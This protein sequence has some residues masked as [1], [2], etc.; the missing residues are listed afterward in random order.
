MASINLAFINLIYILENYLCRKSH[1]IVTLDTTEDPPSCSEGA[2]ESRADQSPAVTYE[3]TKY[4]IKS[5]SFHETSKTF[6]NFKFDLLTL[7]RTT[8]KYYEGLISRRG[9]SP[10]ESSSIAGRKWRKFNDEFEI[11]KNKF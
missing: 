6:L 7:I 2:F 10:A 5:S 4:F 1:S 3:L 11:K 9:K 8:H